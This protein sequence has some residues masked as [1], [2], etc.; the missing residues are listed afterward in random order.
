MN[1][2]E[3]HAGGLLTGSDAALEDPLERALGVAAGVMTESVRAISSACDRLPGLEEPLRLLLS[4]RGRVVF[5]GLGKSGL[6]ASK[7]AATFAST[8]TPSQFVHA[9][10]ALHGD[11]GMVVPGD[12]VIA[13]SKSGET[14]EVVQFVRMLK[15]RG[16][17]V[18]AMT[19]C[20]GSSTLCGL[21]DATIDACVDK[22]CDPWDLVPTA[23]TTVSL[24]VG[25]ALAVALMVDRDFG[26][27]R[28]REHHPGGSIGQQLRTGGGV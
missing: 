16:I 10:D 28:F 2:R 19:G 1:E 22:E 21:A 4:N 13:L 11:A 6:I 18:I 17:P 3:R 20:R 7:L 15:R 26:P 8:G 24:V 27:E 14:G 12:V 25:D 5:T 9:A 23:S